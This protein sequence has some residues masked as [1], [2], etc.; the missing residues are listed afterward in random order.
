[1]VVDSVRRGL[2][3]A[4]YKS[5]SINGFLGATRWGSSF[6]CPTRWGSSAISRTQHCKFLKLS[7]PLYHITILLQREGK[8]LTRK[9]RGARASLASKCSEPALPRSRNYIGK[10]NLLRHQT[11]SWHT[12]SLSLLLAASVALLSVLSRAYDW[13]VLK[14]S[15]LC[16][17]VLLVN[18]S[19][20]NQS[21]R[22]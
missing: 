15:K 20:Y 4:R 12:P 2:G 9:W 3:E 18:D 21:A 22:Q 17:L 13:G 1:V 5:I 14:G 10:K 11:I 6:R 7:Q 16:S 19:E 8:C